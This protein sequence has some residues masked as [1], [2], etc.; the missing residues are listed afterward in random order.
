[1]N[2]NLFAASDRDPDVRIYDRR[3][4]KIV[5]TFENIHRGKN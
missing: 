4:S 2:P 3:N 1:M 5:R